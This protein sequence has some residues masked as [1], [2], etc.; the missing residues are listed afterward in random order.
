MNELAIISVDDEKIIL[1]SLKSQFEINFQNKFL[2]EF[3]ESAE[4]ALEL[5]DELIEDGIKIILVI[6]D[7]QMPGMKGDE[8]ALILSK[9]LPTT[10]VILLTGQISQDLAI[11]FVNK[12]IFVNI[13]SKPWS[14]KE[15]VTL[16]K[17][18]ANNVG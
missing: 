18:I 14:E 17:N 13:V 7:Y 3:A 8:F 5:I 15:L 4:E 1:D 11:D 2:F 10:K 12:N 9:K 16:V 6:S